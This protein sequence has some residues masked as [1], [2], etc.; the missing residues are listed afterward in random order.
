MSVIDTANNHLNIQG[1]ML[2]SIIHDVDIQYPEG[3]QFYSP[4][5]SYPEY[6]FTHLS[7]NTNRVYQGVRNCLA[8][9]GLDEANFGKKSWNPLGEYVRKKDNVF[10]LC[11]FVYH[12]RSSESLSEFYAKC[13]HASV[14]RALI[15][16]VYIATGPEGTISFGNAPLQSCDFQKILV[17]TGAASM[18]QFYNNININVTAKDLRL[19]T[20]KRSILGNISSSETRDEEDA[21]L[22]SL[23]EK[24][25]LNNLYS[26]M[27]EIA[28]RIS[29]YN[30]ERI[31]K[32][33]HYNYHKYIIHKEI[34]NSDVVL[35]VPKLKTHEKVGLTVGLKG[36]VGTVGHKDCLAHH[37]FGPPQK[38]GDEYPDSGKLQILASR[39]HDFAQKRNYPKSIS[40]L[41]DIIDK[42]TGRFLRK[43]LKKIRSG[44]WS[45]ND[46]AWRMTLDLARIIHK[47][48]SKGKLIRGIPRKNIVFIDGVIGGEGNGPLSPQ[49]VDSRCMIFS[50]NVVFG[51]II[52]CKL[53]GWD[54]NKIPLIH[55]AIDNE[56]L[57]SNGEQN[58]SKCVM[59]G[60]L[61]DAEYIQSILG[62]KFIPSDGW[63][64]FLL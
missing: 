51:D 15:D 60:Q 5:E 6:P 54:K 1:I 42:N 26:G 57:Y 43:C 24:S 34:L 27:K 13:T 46:T 40:P 2:S 49:P 64:N 32:F 48:D 20:N 19:F 29:D 45:G 61:V 8:Q 18:L 62:R 10:L 39:F 36:F 31:Q 33:H 16:Y 58:G 47:A 23:D 37:R 38:N 17:D 9:C 12:R 4:S 50:D 22:I 28:F 35:S 14:I 55:N 25:L 53:M 59:N 7:T 21:M 3:D 11:N 44:A 52:S 56:Y 30:P 41:L 63:K